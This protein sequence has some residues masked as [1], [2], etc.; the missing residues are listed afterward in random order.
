MQLR[1]DQDLRR[2]V[3][4]RV[5]ERCHSFVA[6]VPLQLQLVLLEVGQRAEALE[7][8]VRARRRG[9]LASESLCVAVQLL[10]ELCGKRG[11]REL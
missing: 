11:M 8:E 5:E 1:G 7:R 2:A 4:R 3:L 10:D 9:R 6:L